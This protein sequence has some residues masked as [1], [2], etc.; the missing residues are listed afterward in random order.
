MHGSMTISLASGVL[1][2]E[3]W[4]WQNVRP[5]AGGSHGAHW[6]L[7]DSQGQPDGPAASLNLPGPQARMVCL[8]LTPV[9]GPSLALSMITVCLIF[10]LLLDLQR[11]GPHTKACKL[12]R[13]CC[14]AF[15]AVC[16]CCNEQ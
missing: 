9:A 15:K 10:S 4:H 1:L 14:L 12:Y 5:S 13:D 3:G 16:G 8:S 2:C 7:S 11:F 6:T